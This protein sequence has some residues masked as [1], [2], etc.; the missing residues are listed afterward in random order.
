MRFA[1]IIHAVIS[2]SETESSDKLLGLSHILFIR[3][4]CC[5]SMDDT[6]ARMSADR[7]AWHGRVLQPMPFLTTWQT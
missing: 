6:P 2:D 3:S 1:Q 7:S 5:S 4:A